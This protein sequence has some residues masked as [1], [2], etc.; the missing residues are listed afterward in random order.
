MYELGDRK[1][2]QL[3]RRMPQVLG[4][5][6]ATAGTAFLWELFLQR[7]P[8]SVRMVLASTGASQSL[9]ELADLADKVMDVA[10]PTVTQINTQFSSDVDQLRSEISDLKSLFK[11][12]HLAKPSFN[13]CPSKF[14]RHSPSSAPRKTQPSSNLIGII[15]VLRMMPKSANLCALGCETNRPVTNADQC[16]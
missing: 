14:P 8:L 1:P 11:S 9:E 7:L 16:S 4:D 5:K 12:M 13:H 3:F 10:A 2:S 15:I 6:G